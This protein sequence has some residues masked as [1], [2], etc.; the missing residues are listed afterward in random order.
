MSDDLS[1]RLLHLLEKTRWSMN[2][3]RLCGESIDGQAASAI[4]RDAILASD[5]LKARDQRVREECAQ[6]CEAIRD[7]V[8]EHAPNGAECFDIAAAAIRGD[9]K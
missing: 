5:W 4:Y 1:T 2:A 8:K 9:A 3:R 7:A 6:V